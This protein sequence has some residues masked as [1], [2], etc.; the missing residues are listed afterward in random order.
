MVG[1]L[2]GQEPAPSKCALMSTSSVVRKD[3][4][5]WVLSHEGEKWTV[6]LDVGDLGGHL[7][8]TFR[9][10][11]ATLAAGVHLDIFSACACFCSSIR[12]PWQGSGRQDHVHPLRKLRSSIS[13]VVWSCRQPLASVGAVLSFLDGSQGVILR[14]VSYGPRFV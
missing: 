8:F 10:W 1:W 7:D 13:R 4:K 5:D 11:S 3:M 9:R 2:V 6:K 12:L 14:I